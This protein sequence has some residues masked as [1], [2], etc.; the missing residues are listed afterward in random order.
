[1]RIATTIQWRSL[2]P[3]KTTVLLFMML[4]SYT[5]YDYL[6]Y[7]HYYQMRGDDSL[8]AHWSWI[9]SLL[10]GVWWLWAE[11]NN[12]YSQQFGAGILFVFLG[13]AL[14][15]GIELRNLQA[16]SGTERWEMVVCMLVGVV[17]FVGYMKNKLLP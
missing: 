1:M 17:S 8:F 3:K 10:V 14:S 7:R 6:E 16:F 9:L 12:K 4:I 5:V 15:M 13:P 11:I 2:I